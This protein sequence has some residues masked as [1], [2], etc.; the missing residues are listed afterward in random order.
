MFLC[1]SR[2]VKD[3]SA[4]GIAVRYE[5]TTGCALKGGNVI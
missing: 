4:H 3:Q 2:Q 1:S 5:R